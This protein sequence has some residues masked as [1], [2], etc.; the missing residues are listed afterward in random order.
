MDVDLLRV[1]GRCDSAAAAIAQLKISFPMEVQ[2]MPNLAVGYS[3]IG[4]KMLLDAH[5]LQAADTGALLWPLWS[6]ILIA[7][8]FSR[9][10]AVIPTHRVQ[11]VGAAR[12][13]L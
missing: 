12:I 10:S 1:R 7:S 5:L 4:L 6:L 3:Q 2:R 13:F 9:L 8:Q 11:S